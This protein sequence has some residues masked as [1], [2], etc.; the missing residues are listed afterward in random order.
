MFV[1]I[2]VPDKNLVI[3]C[4]GDYWHM[5]PSKYSATD[6]N[7]STKR[8]AA[9]QWEKDRKRKLFM[10]SKGYKVVELWE[11]EINNGDYRKLDIYI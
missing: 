8:T 9:E 11:H 1:D 10:E 5:S 6:Y 7:K 4:F 2:Y 3:E